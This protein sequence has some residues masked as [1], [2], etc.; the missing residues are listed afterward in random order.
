M[1]SPAGTCPSHS[2]GDATAPRLG[3]EGGP[4]QGSARLWLP[5]PWVGDGDSRGLQPRHHPQKR[6]RAGGTREP[7]KREPA[8]H[9]S[10]AAFAIIWS[11]PLPRERVVFRYIA[12]CREA[13]GAWL[14]PARPRQ[15]SETTL[16]ASPS[17]PLTPPTPPSSQN[18]LQLP[19]DTCWHGVPA[20]GTRSHRAPLPRPPRRGR[21]PPCS[22]VGGPQLSHPMHETRLMKLPCPPGCV[23]GLL[24]LPAHPGLISTAPRCHPGAAG[25]VPEEAT[26]AEGVFQL[27]HSH[28]GCSLIRK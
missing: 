3:R 12:L 19:R 26:G 24:H 16:G 15:R 5:G 20:M 10:L 14:L 23:H 28:L 25:E 22:M 27:A 17:H 1:G 7:T 2:G 9:P 11:A 21:H 8:S 6:S 13:N 18:P 4:M